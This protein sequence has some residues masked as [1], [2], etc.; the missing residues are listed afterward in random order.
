VASAPDTLNL[1]THRDQ[2]GRRHLA[3]VRRGLL[4]LL[5]LLLLAALLNTFGQRPATSRAAGQSARL[6]VY[7]PMHARSG[8]IY[9][10]RFR[11]DA[12]AE[13]KQATLVLDA[14]WADGYTVNG[15][16]PQPLTEASDNGR[17]VFGFG[18]VPAGRHV[19]FWLSLQVNP[20]NVGRHDQTV[21]LTDGD[22]RL[23]TVHRD[24]TIFP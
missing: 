21:T 5:A 14:G 11:I 19:T 22:R 24:I 10:A 2:R 18:H 3:W 1:E 17:L 6:T 15:V 23:A 4:T 9:A 7:A 20:T 16:A 8:L 13:L 12:I